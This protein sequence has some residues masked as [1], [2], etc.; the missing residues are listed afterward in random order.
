MANFTII[1]LLN[2]IMHAEKAYLLKFAIHET[3]LSISLNLLTQA[4]ISGPFE[5]NLMT[6]LLNILFERHFWT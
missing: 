6:S 3:K 5:R 4:K 1:E 2:Y